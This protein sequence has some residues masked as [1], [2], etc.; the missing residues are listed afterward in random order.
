[1]AKKTA[2]KKGVAKKIAVKGPQSQEQLE[3]LR[4]EIG[5]QLKELQL[6]LTNLKN[7]LKGVFHDP[8]IGHDF[9]V[10]DPRRTDKK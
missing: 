3:E 6:G 5:E 10:G 8:H 9:F 1:M 7:K 4:E 2:T